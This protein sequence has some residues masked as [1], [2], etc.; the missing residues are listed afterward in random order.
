MKIG[1]FS[2]V[3]GNLEALET[4]LAYFRSEGVND[5]LC[6]GDIVGYGANPEECV[7][8]VRGLRGTVV[9]GNHDRAAINR[10]SLSLFNAAARE[11]ILWTRRRLSD[12]S[13]D[14]LE[15]LELVE[16]AQGFHLVHARPSAPQEW[17]YVQTLSDVAHE[18]GSFFEPVCLIGHS[19]LHFAAE[20]LPSSETPRFVAEPEFEISDSTKHLVNVGSVGQPRDGD[21]RLCLVIFDA[22]SNR[23]SF[24]RLSYDIPAAQRKILYAGL[25]ESLAFRLSRGR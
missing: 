22:G 2:D 15:S 18:L 6:L 16:I 21:P 7:E 20:K 4:A 11:A 25:P 14:F 12:Q 8:L 24:Q 1:I 23:F 17:E 19:H 10:A 3:H 5:Y 13:R 9:A